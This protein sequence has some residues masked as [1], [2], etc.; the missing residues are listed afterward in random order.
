ME[1]NV[2]EMDSAV[3][4]VSNVNNTKDVSKKLKKLV[5]S[6][7]FIA[8]GY[9][10]KVDP[11]PNAP[12]II[13]NVSGKAL[14]KTSK[15]RIVIGM[16]LVFLASMGSLY[17]ITQNPYVQFLQLGVEKDIKVLKKDPN[18]NTSST[19]KWLKKYKKRIQAEFFCEMGLIAGIL[20]FISNIF[21]YSFFTFYGGFIGLTYCALR[22]MWTKWSVCE[23]VKKENEKDLLKDVLISLETVS[24]SM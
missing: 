20:G 23:Q 10:K 2:K 12:V 11:S 4:D 17:I 22:I 16:I 8:K 24:N 18:F 19:R 9:E 14:D 15:E 3:K 21:V 7:N 13:N 1:V 6:L 5:G